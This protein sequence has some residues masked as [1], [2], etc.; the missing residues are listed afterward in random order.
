MFT[1]PRG[2]LDRFQDHLVLLNG[3]QAADA[4]V[5][6][7]GLVIGC[8]QTHGVLRPEILQNLQADMAIEQQIGTS[9]PLLAGDNWSANDY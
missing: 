3:G 6:G 5:V 8:D 4:L 7:E 2:G 9:V 1:C